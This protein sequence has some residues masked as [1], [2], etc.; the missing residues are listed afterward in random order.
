MMMTLMILAVGLV[1]YVFWTRHQ[2]Q[3]DLAPASHLRRPSPST[4]R[5]IANAASRPVRAQLVW[6]RS[7][8]G[9]TCPASTLLRNRPFNAATAPSL[10]ELGCGHSSCTCHYEPFT[11][12]RS[13]MR[14]VD[15]DRRNGIR[16]E[17]GRRKVLD[18]RTGNDIWSQVY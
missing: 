4:A 6:L 12:R 2:A 1:G 13:A 16:F 15:M 18:R 10:V 5:V 3:S 8:P 11:D 17:A 14:R 7:E 9:C